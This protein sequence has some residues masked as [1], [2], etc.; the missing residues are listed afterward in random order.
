MMYEY[1]AFTSLPGSH[2]RLT[3]NI[4]NAQDSCVA[5]L[6][7]TTLVGVQRPG[8]RYWAAWLWCRCAVGLGVVEG[9]RVAARRLRRGRRVLHREHG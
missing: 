9:L 5:D 3:S 4:C 2:W 8:S 1:P 7:H 6:L